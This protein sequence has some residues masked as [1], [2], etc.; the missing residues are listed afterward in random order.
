MSVYFCKEIREIQNDLRY[1][2]AIYDPIKLEN[3]ICS[4]LEE[5]EDF[6]TMFANT[7]K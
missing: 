1:Q 4:F 5:V 3:N 2:F 6:V 7:G